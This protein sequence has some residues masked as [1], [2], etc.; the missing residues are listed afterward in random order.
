MKTHLLT[1]LP[2]NKNGYLNI[3]A[4]NDL[5]QSVKHEYQNQYK[6]DL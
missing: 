3:Y 1:N 5:E 4:S 6:K 2:V